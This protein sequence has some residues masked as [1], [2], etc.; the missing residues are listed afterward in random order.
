MQ[1]IIIS[2]LDMWPATITS[3]PASAASPPTGGP[4]PPPPPPAT[5]S[6][7]PYRPF[8]SPFHEV[9]FRPNPFPS[10]EPP[11]QPPPALTPPLHIGGSGWTLSPPADERTTEDTVRILLTQ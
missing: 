3:T 2:G 10:P 9:E 5:T 7:T 1:A 4:P 6:S 11:A 8:E